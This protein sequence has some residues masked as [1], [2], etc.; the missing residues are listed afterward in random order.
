MKKQIGSSKSMK[1]YKM[2]GS[3]NGPGPKTDSI[4]SN[5][6]VGE[7]PI[8]YTKGKNPKSEIQPGPRKEKSNGKS[9]LD[10]LKENV[11]GF[12]KKGGSVKKTSKKK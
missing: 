10:K 4:P 7:Y 8:G 5:K 2:G 12:F 11:K 6:S 9:S 1:K 3:N